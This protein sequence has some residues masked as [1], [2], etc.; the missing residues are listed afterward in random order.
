[1]ERDFD[2]VVIGAGPAGE[3]LAGRL[4]ERG[5]KRV[6]IVERDL[7][8]GECS[9]FA[10]MPSKALLRPAEVLREVAR[11]P[12]AAEAVTGELD[13]DAVLARRDRIVNNLDDDNQ[14]P[15]LRARDIELVR[16]H[17][18]LDGERR[19]RVGDDVLVAREAVVIAVGSGALMPPIP[20][21]A[22]AGAWS[23]REIT[24]AREAPGRLVVLGG[25]VVG[26]EMAQAWASLGSRVTVIE[27]QHQLLPRE[28]PFAGDELQSAL[29]RLGV[30]VR[31]GRRATEVGRV[32]EEITVVLESGERVAGDRLLV[33]IGRRPL[34]GDLGL[35]TVGLPGGY[36]EVDDQLRVADH[37]WL[38]AIGDVNGRSLLTHSGK[39]QARIAADHILGEGAAAIGDG[40]G[41]PRVVFTDPQVAAVGQTLGAALEAGVAAEAIDLPTSGT[42]GGSF[43]GRGAPGTTRFVVDTD[44]EVLIGATF[45]G[46]DV[47]E[48][49]H[50]AT[51][52]I[53]AE[54]PLVTL[55]H[56]IPSFPT[57]SELWLKFVEAYERERRTT[58][59]TGQVV[60]AAG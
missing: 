18:R 9:F 46:P 47:A 27:A 17:A 15:W 20:G 33:A 1:M 31:T 50:A 5:A 44:R 53:V 57:R 56:A 28:E 58:L 43:Y 2:V 29:E 26:V 42:A 25:G 12:G 51:I 48:L 8:G 49:V 24:T 7:V 54:V 36:I 41:A 37:P 34:T 16:G 30:D 21:L 45:V 35:E 55:A 14:V 40:P 38:Y 4:S 13:V 59:H 6:A 22:G 19:V 32:G 10:C 60:A 23:S 52:A 39:Y 11:V 3:V